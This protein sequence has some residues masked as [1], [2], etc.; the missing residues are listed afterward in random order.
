MERAPP[1]GKKAKK[2]AGFLAPP[3]KA[4][5]PYGKTGESP[6]NYILA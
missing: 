6:H 3:P 1:L 5:F 2:G 4:L